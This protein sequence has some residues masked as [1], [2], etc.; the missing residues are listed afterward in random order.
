MSL[1]G[2]V[3]LVTGATRGIG[4][5]IAK[6][7]VKAGAT[8]YI[9]GRTVNPSTQ[10]EISLLGGQCIPVQCDHGKDDQVE[11]VFEKIK[12]EQ[13]GKLDILVNN[14]YA[15]VSTITDNMKKKFYEQPISVWDTVNDVGLRSNYVAAHYA[16]NMMIPN[17]QGLIV[18]ISSAGGLRYLF[19]IPY[20]VGKAANDRMMADMAVELR[21]HNIA[22]V[23]LWPGAVLTE[24]I[25]DLVSGKQGE[26][27]AKQASKMFEKEYLEDPTFSG[28]AIVALACDKDIMKKSGHI[29][30]VAE[31]GREYGF[32]DIGGK[33]PLSFRQLKFIMHR[34]YPKLEWIVPEFLYVPWW[35]IASWTHKFW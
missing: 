28:K 20:G 25:N 2:K 35:I 34:T 19:N 22:A 10:D 14:A 24:H 23:S 33:Q 16:A 3:C 13:N 17:K 1:S 5:G 26:I 7:L 11:K 18:N 9:T 32:K 31:L 8:V 27:A 30:I 29:L 15:G 21:K 4:K 6:M 12:N